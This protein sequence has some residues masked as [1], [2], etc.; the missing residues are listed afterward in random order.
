MKK[1]VSDFKSAAV[2]N[3]TGTVSHNTV[4][5]AKEPAGT[6]TKTRT[7]NDLRGVSALRPDIVFFDQLVYSQ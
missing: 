7:Q 5:A 3:V 4:S 1:V 2:R 6:R